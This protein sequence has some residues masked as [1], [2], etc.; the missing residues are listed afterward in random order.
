MASFQRFEDIKAWQKARELNRTIYAITSKDSFSRDYGLRDQIRRAS[1]S[2]MANIAEGF[3]RRTNKD[4][5]NFLV[6][7]HGSAAETQSHLYVALDLK[8]ISDEIFQ[9]LYQLLDEISR[10]LWPSANTSAK[11]KTLQTPRT[12]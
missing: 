7:A 2:I 10:I 11:P 3:G 12:P 1:V 8:Y 6:I 9:D 4:F 5:A